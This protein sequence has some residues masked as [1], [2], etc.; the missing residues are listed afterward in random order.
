VVGKDLISG[1]NAVSPKGDIG[2]FRV[3]RK[4]IVFSDSPT[5]KGHRVK[6]AAFQQAIRALPAEWLLP[7]VCARQVSTERHKGRGAR[8]ERDTAPKRGKVCWLWWAHC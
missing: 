2:R 6:A 8:V 5:V 7:L 3:L 1:H 4:E